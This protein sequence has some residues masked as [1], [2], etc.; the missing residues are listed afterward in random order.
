MKKNL[1]TSILWK[2]ILILFTLAGCNHPIERSGIVVDRQT[3]EPLQGVTIDIYLKTQRRD[4]LKEKVFT[5]SNGHFYIREKR[6]E[7][8]LFLLQ[9][10]GYIGHVNSLS[11]INDTIKL[12]REKD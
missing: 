5:D 8:L 9:K 4:S 12:E 11:I 1:K 7:D 10:N 3:K 6:D 2:M